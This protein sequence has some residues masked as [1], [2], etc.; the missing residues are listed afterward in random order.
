VRTSEASVQT[1]RRVLV[2]CSD[3]AEAFDWL[4]VVEVGGRLPAGP[5]DEYGYGGGIDNADEVVDNSGGA[6]VD[7]RETDCEHVDI[8][9]ANEQF[10]GDLR[11]MIRAIPTNIDWIVELAE[12]EQFVHIDKC[13]FDFI[14]ELGKCKVAF[15]GEVG[16]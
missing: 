2:H 14:G 10:V 7:R 4:W 15:R 5:E 12:S 13:G 16:E 9:V 3:A 11:Q 1:A 8:E 6:L